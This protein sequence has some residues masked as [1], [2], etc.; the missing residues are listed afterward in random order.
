CVFFSLLALSA[1]GQNGVIQGSVVDAVTNDPIPFANVLVEGQSKGAVS[2]L[3]GKFIVEGLIPGL[4]NL[5]ASFIG[6]KKEIEFEIEVSNSRSA[7][8]NFRLESNATE[9]DVA[10]I[11]GS[12]FTNKEE[13]PLSVRKIG[14]N[15]V[16]RNPGG[17]RDI[18]RAIRSLPGVAS[19]PSFRNDIIIRGGS[20]SENRF[21]IDGIEIP[22]INHFATQGASGGPVGL[23]NVDFI[24]DVEFYSG[25]FPANR[26]NALSSV[27][28]FG[29]KDGRTDRWSVN[30]VIGT[31]DVGLTLEGPTGK[32]SSLIMSARRSYLQLLFEQLGLPF[33]PTY[34]DFQYKWKFKPNSK[35]E[36]TLIGLGAIDQF[37]LNTALAEDPSDEDFESNN[38]ILDLL[39][40]DTQW[41]YT[42][43]AKWDQ[44]VEDGRWTYVLSRNMLNNR[45]Y[46]HEDNDENLPLIRDYLS[47]EIENKFRVERKIFSESGWK[48]NFGVN[49][50]YAKYNNKSDLQQFSFSSGSIEQL[51]SNSAFDMHKAG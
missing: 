14:V 28:D 6:Y 36:L 51:N 41:N 16:K 26:G 5:E 2:D 39:S 19:I 3:D 1:F 4:Y 34:N 9:L 25:A 47:Q 50:E 13:S 37:S 30:G 46:K 44:F 38:Y 20:S 49:Y 15:E 17:N 45:S 12:S 27:F 10:E 24:Q 32:K 23:I 7:I 8:V 40:V 31:S 48:L 33:L 11:E 35:N 29:F 42:V 18:S 43:G 22:N 21:Y